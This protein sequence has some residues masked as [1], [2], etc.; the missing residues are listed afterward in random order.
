MTTPFMQQIRLDGFLSFAPGSAPV[1][2]RPLNVLIGPN[3]SGKSN[4]IEAF[5]LLRATATGL[6]STVRQGGGVREWL[7][8]GVSPPGN[9]VMEAHFERGGAPLRYRVEFANTSDRAEIVDEVLQDDSTKFYHYLNG[10][11][12]LSVRGA[13]GQRS[14]LKVDGLNR[15]ESVLSQ[16]KDPSGLPELALCAREFS[17][18]QSFR[19]WTFGR[20]APV[21]LGQP[22][23]APSDVLLPD[24]SN[25][26]LLLNELEHSS[27]RA[28]LY[29]WLQRFLPRFERLSTLTVGGTIQFFLHEEG[30]HSPVPARRISDGTLRFLALLVTLLSD[31][32]PPL[33]CIEEPELGLHP[34]ALSV[35]A[36]LLV[37]ASA[38]M[39]LV[40]TT[41]SDVLVSR[42]NE[43][44]SLLIADYVGGTHLRRLDPDHLDDWL[45]NYR[46][47]DLWRMGHLGGN[48]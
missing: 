26:G 45:Q 12:Y 38:R 41:H 35:V 8:K 11:P 39:Q 36:E 31:D 33:I 18:I 34:D 15:F 44:E 6:A 19:E 7:W 27:K 2:M 1:E 16:R 14:D 4:L 37:E 21:R 29:E 23:T 40:V 30:L 28:D 46:L 25:L 9:A 17:R 43:P 3:G 47:G 13:T 42:I 20:I 32:P 10:E 5:E 22:T 24:A 48:P